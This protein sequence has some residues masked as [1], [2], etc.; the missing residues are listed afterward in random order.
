MR[1]QLTFD[2]LDPTRSQVIFDER[3]NTAMRPS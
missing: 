2:A 3:S 1:G